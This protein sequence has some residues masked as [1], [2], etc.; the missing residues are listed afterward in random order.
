MSRNVNLN[1]VGFKPSARKTAVI[2]SEGIDTTFT[3]K[4]TSGKEVY[5]G[6]LTGPVDAQYAA[7]R[8]TRQISVISRLPEPM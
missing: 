7:E 4:D 1:Q 8:F 3:L 6:K 2:R 5:S